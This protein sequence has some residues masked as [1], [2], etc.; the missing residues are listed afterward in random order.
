MEL[1]AYHRWQPNR[2]DSGEHSDIDVIEWESVRVH[3]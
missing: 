2:F 1:T 3:G